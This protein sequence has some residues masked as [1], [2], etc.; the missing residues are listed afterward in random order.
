MARSPSSERRLLGAVGAVKREEWPF[1]ILMFSYVFLVIATFWILKPLK[2]GLFIE[3]YDATGF[4]LAGRHFQAAEAELLAKVL[5]MVVAA[6]AVAGFTWLARRHRRERLTAIL[7]AGFVA[8]EL[9]YAQ[10]LRAPGATTVWTFYLFGDLFSTLMVATFFAFLNDS[11]TTE[12]AKRLYGFVGL[13][14]VLG[15][16]VGSSLLGALI[17]SLQAPIWLL[18]CAAMG[19][20]V[21][22]VAMAAGRLVKPDATRR[23]PAPEDA[24]RR[25]PALEGAALVLRSSYLLSIAAIVGIYEIVSTVMDFQFTSTVAHYLNGNAIETH[26]SRVFAITNIASMLVQFFLTPMIMQTWG[27]GIA[28]SSCPRPRGSARAHSFAFPRSS[29]AAFSTQPTM[30]SATRSTSRRRKPFTCRRPRTRSTRRRHS[31]TC[32]SSARR[33]QWRSASA[34]AWDGGSTISRAFAGCRWW[35]SR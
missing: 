2:K 19:V 13:G 5:N 35:H 31:S 32:S 3:H 22:V 7:M 1:A 20:V 16:V 33:R 6:V 11:V 18:A 12:A 28:V 8:A 21:I 24:P 10:L 34:W 15:G 4:V 30:P 29:P 26:L 27:L 25:N 17:G 14:A 9:L 23:G